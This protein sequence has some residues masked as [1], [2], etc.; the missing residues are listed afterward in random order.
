MQKKSEGEKVNLISEEQNPLL[1][2]WKKKKKKRKL[3]INT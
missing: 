3:F 2:Q 1:I